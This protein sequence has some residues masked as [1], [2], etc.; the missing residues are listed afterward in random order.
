MPLPDTVTC[1]DCRGETT[2][3]RYHVLFKSRNGAQVGCPACE[4]SFWVS[5][6]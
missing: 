6:T 1:A 2:F 4:Y 5:F 3:G